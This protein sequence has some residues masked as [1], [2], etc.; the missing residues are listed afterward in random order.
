M[1]TNY[2]LRHR[3]SETHIGKATRGWVFLWRGWRDPHES[4]YGTPITTPAEALTAITRA[5]DD[6]ATIHTEWGETITLETLIERITTARGNRN[7]TSLPG[8]EKACDCNIT[9]TDGDDINFT[10][11]A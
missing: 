3:A 11:F 4:P 10:E 5:I 7:H 8:C 9:H 6:G 2:Y 1:G